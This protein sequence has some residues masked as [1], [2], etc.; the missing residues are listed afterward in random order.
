MI[1]KLKQTQ[2]PCVRVIVISVALMCF[3]LCVRLGSSAGQPDL[4]LER[5][6]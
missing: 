5:L 6:K 3:G 4:D 1:L 2:V